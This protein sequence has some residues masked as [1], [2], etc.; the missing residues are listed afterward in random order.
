MGD[1]R[2]TGRTDYQTWSKAAVRCS[3]IFIAGA[4]VL[5]AAFVVGLKVLDTTAV[6]FWASI[7]AGVIWCFGG[8]LVLMKMQREE[9]ALRAKASKTERPEIS[10]PLFKELYDEYEYNQ[11]DGLTK[12]TFFHTW[13]LA[14]IE[15]YHHI[16][17]LTFT[18]KHH[19]IA[20]DLSEAEIS[21]I[22]DEETDS[23]DEF[24]MNLQDFHCLDEMFHAITE[25]CRDSAA[26]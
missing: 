2:K 23:P 21:I 4:C 11:L 22:I 24:T 18:K 8:Y 16:I 6:L 1:N 26:I 3:Q 20:I 12:N 15:D 14:N 5:G 7:I 13:K 19:E 25:A 17:S 9:K 10:S